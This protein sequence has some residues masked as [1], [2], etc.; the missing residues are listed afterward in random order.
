MNGRPISVAYGTP[1]RNYQHLLDQGT[2][3]TFGSP[4]QL[5]TSQWNYQGPQMVGTRQSLPPA[6]AGGPSLPTVGGAGGFNPQ[7]STGISVGPVVPQNLVNQQQNRMRSFQ[8]PTPQEPGRDYSPFM[9]Q[10][11]S[12]VGGQMNDAATDFGRDA[13][14]A[15]AQHLLGT[16]QARARAGTGWGGAMLGDYTSRLGNQQQMLSALLAMLS[17]FGG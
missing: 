15:N 2:P 11:Q 12:L 8:A 1:Q 14:Y 16:Q 4:H 17:Q 6:P 13:S 7:I 3:L 10:L 9:Q 5:G